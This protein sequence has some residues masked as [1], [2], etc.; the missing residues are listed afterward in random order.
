M[1]F[2]E[3]F[4]LT[5]WGLQC[6]HDIPK[7]T[8]VSIYAGQLYREEDANEL[9]KGLDHGDEYFA[10]LD[11]IETATPLKEGYEPGVTYDSDTEE[12]KASDSDSDYDATKVDDDD[13]FTT[14]SRSAGNREI[15]T[16][17]ARTEKSQKGGPARQNST[18]S[19]SD[20]D[21]LVTMEPKAGNDGAVSKALS[22]RKMFGKNEKPYVM[23]AKKCG[24][25]GRYFNV[26]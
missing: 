11:L 23:D 5:G 1:N 22:L 14:K 10:E 12:E 2:I 15:L 4:L 25:V 7:G 16:R 8:F 6:A 21:M 20:G 24:N 13:D 18:D 17:S 19:G 26:S 3:L 9:C